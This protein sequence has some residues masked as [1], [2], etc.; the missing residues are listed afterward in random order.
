MQKPA[1]RRVGL[2]AQVELQLPLQGLR[3]EPQG[4]LKP[5]EVA[6]QRHGGRRVRDLAEHV[7]HDELVVDERQGYVRPLAHHGADRV[8][9]LGQPGQRT[10]PHRGQCLGQP[11]R[12]DHVCRGHDSVLVPEQP[13]DLGHPAFDGPVRGAEQMPVPAGR[14]DAR[15]VSP[16]PRETA[17]R[18]GHPGHVDLGLGQS[19]EDGPVRGEGRLHTQRRHVP[20]TAHHGDLVRELLLR[21]AQLKAHIGLPHEVPL[22]PPVPVLL[23]QRPHRLTERLERR[24][25]VPRPGPVL[26]DVLPPALRV[27]VSRGLG[28]YGE[29][30]DAHRFPDVVPALVLALFPGPLGVVR[31]RG[32]R[33][34]GQ[35]VRHAAGR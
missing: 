7:P 14:V 8:R 13:G 18:P 6:L 11:Y 30:I 33:A 34:Q 28:E 19:L 32:L 35:A 24:E 29:R 27:V 2:L 23:P 21:G 25:R 31:R 17:V 15:S 22:V 4:A 10:S 5:C 26:D 1:A 20:R 12:L 3:F 16:G 9:R